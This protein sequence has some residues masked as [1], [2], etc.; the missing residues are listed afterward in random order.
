MRRKRFAKRRS[1]N[2]GRMILYR[3]PNNA[4][5][6]REFFTK[7][8]SRYGGTILPAAFAAGQALNIP[9]HGNDVFTPFSWATAIGAGITW[10]NGISPAA[11]AATGHSTFGAVN[12]YENYLVLG[13]SVKVWFNPQIA[14]DQIIVTLTPTNTAGGANPTNVTN[15]LKQPYNRFKEFRIA[16]SGPS[17][18]K[19]YIKWSKFLGVGKQFYS[20]DP[21]VGWGGI[22]N[23]APVNPLWIV[24]NINTLDCAVPAVAGGIPFTIEV[25]HYVKYAKFDAAQVNP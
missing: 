22:Y 7:L 9:M 13:T 20:N 18:L 5:L 14:G 1:P 24:M 8:R 4:V 12:L 6:P 16:G 15:A 21:A 23:A 17:P 2:N 10:M 25:K 11:L 3:A 19:F